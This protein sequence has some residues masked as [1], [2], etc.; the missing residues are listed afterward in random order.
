MQIKSGHVAVIGLLALTVGIMISPFINLS[1][2]PV[3]SVTEI[4]SVSSGVNYNA[5]VCVYKNGQEI[6]C[7]HNLLL[8]AGKNMTRDALTN[9]LAA[10]GVPKWIA[11]GNGTATQAP[12]DNVLAT[13]IGTECGLN[14]AS[15]TINFDTVYNNIGN[16]SVT[17]TFTSSC[18]NAIVNTTALYNATVSGANNTFA[19]TTFTSTTLQ[20]NDQ[21]NITWFIFVS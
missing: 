16:W 3:S 12:T 10:G 13:E 15:G 1:L 21:I 11:L 6:D 8:N 4:S 20:A 9:G 7:H 19:E 17:K 14:R 2:L 5:M 18:N